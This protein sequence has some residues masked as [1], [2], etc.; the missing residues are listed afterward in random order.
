MIGGTS[1]GIKAREIFWDYRT[2]KLYRYSYLRIWSEAIGHID[3]IV[4]MDKHSPKLLCASITA[5]DC[6]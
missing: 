1:P 4:L 3:V 2:N 6:T 5:L